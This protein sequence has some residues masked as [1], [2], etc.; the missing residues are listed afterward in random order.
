[1]NDIWCAKT[2]YVRN[3]RT[4]EFIIV[5][6]ENKS[7]IF[8]MYNYEGKYYYLFETKTDVR[9]FF[10]WEESDFKEFLNEEILDNFLINY[11]L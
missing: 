11:P 7:R 3:S 9:N 10:N 5:S 4:F 8:Y 1:M 2:I 6:A